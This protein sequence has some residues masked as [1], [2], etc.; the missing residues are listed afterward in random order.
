MLKLLVD[1]DMP[2]STADLLRSL[3]IDAID[4]RDV[5]LKGATDEKIFLYAQKEEL[6]IITRD[7]EF[8]N[9]VK[10][11]LGSH[12]GIIVVMFPYTFVRS[13]ILDTIRKFFRSV[14]MNKL[15]N[16]LTVLEVEKYRIRTA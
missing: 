16:N 8:G 14:D 3:G 13:Q 10:Y 7:K 12:C 4:A 6:I 5:G 2:R 11:P 15:P 1:E 9:I